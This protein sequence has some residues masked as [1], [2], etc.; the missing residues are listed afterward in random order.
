MLKAELEKLVA[1][2]QANNIHHMAEMQVQSSYVVKVLEL[3]GWR[4]GDWQQGASQGVNTGNFPD[5]VLHDKSKDNMLV[6]ECKDARKLDKLDGY[7]GSGKKR[8]TFEE[9]L[10]GYCRA[11]G[12]YWGVLTNFVEWRLYNVVHK[13][14]YGKRYAF[15]SLLWPKADKRFYTD[16]LSDE[17]LAFL[18]LISREYVCHNKGKIDPNPLY[19][20]KEIILADTKAKFFNKLTGWRETLRNHVNHK[21]KDKYNTDEIDLYTQRILDR[22]IFM[23]VCHDKGIINEDHLR[24][25][26]ETKDNTYKELKNVFKQME[27]KFNT[28]LFTHQPIDD[29]ALDNE[30]IAPIVRQ[31][32]DFDFKDISV[33]IIGEV[34]ENYLGELLRKARKSDDLNVQV[35]T[36]RKSQGIYYTPDYIVDYIVKNTVGELLAKVRTTEEIKKIK[37][38]DPACGSGSFLICAFDCFYKAYELAKNKGQTAAMRDFDIT[39]AILQNNLFGVDLDE[40]AVEITKLNLMLK[41]LEG[42]NW[43]DLPGDKLLPNLSLNIREGNSLISGQMFEKKHEGELFPWYDAEP[44]IPKLIKLR[45]EFHRAK[46]EE[47]KENLLENI[48]VF[49]SGLNRDLNENLRGYFKD[50][51]DQKP[52]N[53]Q[54]AFPEVFVG[55]GPSA[56]SGQGFDAVIGNPPWIQSKFMDMPNKKY[57]EHRY[58][59]ARKQY[60]IFSCFVEKSNE[61][62]KEHGKF[63]F[64]VPSRWIMNPDYIMLRKYLAHKV[65]ITEI[66]DVGEKIFEGVKMPSL[67][68]FFDKSIDEKNNIKNTFKVKYEIENKIS[69]FKTNKLLQG[70]IAKDGQYLF[71][72]TQNN[73]L[74]SIFTKIEEASLNYGDFVT[75]ARGVEIGKKSSIVFTEKKEGYVKFLVGGDMG[76]YYTDSCHYLKLGSRNIDYKQPE[77]YVGEKIIIRKTGTGINATLDKDSYVIQVIYIFKNKQAI[78]DLKYYLGILNSKLMSKYYF[79]KY[80]EEKKIAFP[81]LRQTTVLQLPIRKIDF[82]NKKDKAMHDQLVVLVKEMLKQNKTP[83]LRQRNKHDIAAIDRKIDEL[84]YR[85]YGLN[86]AEKKVIEGN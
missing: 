55:G 17:G 69:I 59:T 68:L 73:K 61:V 42:L 6:V 72:I 14:I 25:V 67:L 31:V 64:I 50:V 49:E 8:K 26:L 85:L 2:A 70:N 35:K 45:N 5:I 63:G 22:L 58:S 53:Y 27:Q 51:K 62:M 48:K 66:V 7:Y 29:F 57:Y 84:V 16:L 75:N 60:D 74:S 34:Y 13:D 44:E 76:R 4:D 18:K 79:A 11:E 19:Y 33:H 77:S 71:S 15:H 46:D 80:G 39:K 12:V 65:R 10:Y 54:V 9:Q 43:R 20:P 38:L 41:A 83:E 30:V 56:R 47:D 52:F 28:E 21:Y 78:Y 23:D 81:H 37:V 1:Q 86:E 40:R 32:T 3:L 82:K 24:A 36:N